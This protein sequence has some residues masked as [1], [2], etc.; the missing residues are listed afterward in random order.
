[1]DSF[2]SDEYDALR[3]CDSLECARYGK[4]LR[5]NDAEGA[6]ATILLKDV[7]AR[8]LARRCS[9]RTLYE[10][11][12]GSCRINRMRTR[13]R[14]FLRAPSST[15]TTC[16]QTLNL[17]AQVEF[18]ART[19][20]SF[21]RRLRLLRRAAERACAC[22]APGHGLWTSMTMIRVLRSSTR[23]RA[24]DTWCSVWRSAQGQRCSGPGFLYERRA[25]HWMMACAA[26]HASCRALMALCEAVV[27]G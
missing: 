4:G 16:S 21:L 23:A 11:C 22:V 18:L 7:P 25:V 15:A 12:T 1:M 9:S 5:S 26:S 3:A 14:A 17:L 2:D 19:R 20:T 8:G 6:C 13:D 10:Q 27:A 24:A